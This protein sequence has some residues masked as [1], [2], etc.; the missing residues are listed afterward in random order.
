M[1]SAA[2]NLADSKASHTTGKRRVGDRNQPSRKDRN[3]RLNV[4]G[5]ENG[6]AAIRSLAAQDRSEMRGESGEDQGETR[7]AEN[8][9]KSHATMESKRVLRQK[10]P[11]KDEV[12]FRKK[13]VEKRENKQSESTIEKLHQFAKNHRAFTLQV[14]GRSMEISILGES[15][16]LGSNWHYYLNHILSRI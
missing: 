5:K 13:G 16:Q 4:V 12:E 8:W 2:H 10:Q 6:A 3:P 7:A 1:P 15:H 9:W 14:K 11:L